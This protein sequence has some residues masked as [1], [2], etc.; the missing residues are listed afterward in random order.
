MQNCLIPPQIQISVWQFNSWAQAPVTNSKNITLELVMKACWVS[1]LKTYCI[2]SSLYY[3]D[4]YARWTEWVWLPASDTPFILK[5]NLIFTI[6]HILKYT[7][8]KTQ[9]WVN[10]GQNTCWVIL[11]QLVGLNIFTQHAGLFNLLFKRYYIAGLKW[12]VH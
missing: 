8:L 1:S 7:G 9:R 10:I 4:Y 5:L 12:A 6:K 11:T 3:V 2:K